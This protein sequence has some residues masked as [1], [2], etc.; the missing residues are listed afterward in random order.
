MLCV[1]SARVRGIYGLWRLERHLF[2]KYEQKAIRRAR[3]YAFG[4]VV[5]QRALNNSSFQNSLF[6][7][8]ACLFLL[9]LSIHFP[10]GVPVEI[11][12]SF[13]R[14]GPRPVLAH[15]DGRE[16]HLIPFFAV[17]V[18]TQSAFERVFYVLFMFAVKVVAVAG[19]SVRRGSSRVELDVKDG[20]S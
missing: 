19:F 10:P 20:V 3:R 7:L 18:V 2:F 13:A 17:E 5:L 6:V 1:L 12:V 9:L 14:R 11:D 15:A 16:V 8:H 4:V